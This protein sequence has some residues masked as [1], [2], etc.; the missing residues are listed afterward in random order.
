MAKNYKVAGWK[1]R[2]VSI[3]WDD[4]SINQFKYA[5]PGYICGEPECGFGADRGGPSHLRQ[6]G[7]IVG[8]GAGVGTPQ[9]A[10]GGIP[11]Y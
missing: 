8:R 11:R 2:A 5:L 6:V 7:S 3:T 9:P 10:S 4:G 1:N